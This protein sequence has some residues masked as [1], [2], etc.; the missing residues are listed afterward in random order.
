[1]WE[2][3]DF[4]VL[5]SFEFQAKKTRCC[6]I[7]TGVKVDLENPS[8]LINNQDQQISLIVDIPI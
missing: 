1:M 4:K 3:N 2:S 8:C 5:C 6:R 7:P